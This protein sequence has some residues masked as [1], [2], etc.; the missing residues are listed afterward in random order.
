MLSVSVCIKPSINFKVYELEATPPVMVNIGYYKYIAVAAPS[1]RRFPT[2][3]A[4]T[5]T[6][7]GTVVALQ[8]LPNSSETSTLLN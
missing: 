6:V 7:T 5:F 4:L 2:G 8:V 3:G 1:T